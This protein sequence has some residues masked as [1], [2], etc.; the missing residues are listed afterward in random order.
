M[1]RG[2]SRIMFVISA[3]ALGAA[4][5]AQKIT[6]TGT[7]GGG[8]PHVRAEWTID[9]A[10]I[11]IEYGRPFLK[12]RPESALMPPGSPWRT[13]ADQATI[14]TSDK[15][16]TFGTL[17]LDAGTPYTINTQP[18]EKEWQFIIGRLGKPG[19]WGVPYQQPREI[20]RTAMALGTAA[21]AA[22]QLTISIDDTAAG[23]T[24]R[25]EWGT[26]SATVPFKVG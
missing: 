3:C 19:Q 7:G 2:F 25:V 11:A 6:E 16:L 4:L 18:G 23:A 1:R 26:V 5:S 13:G 9:G 17:K 22:E 12:G 20:G 21:K 24:L 10:N 15:P 14:I 8:S